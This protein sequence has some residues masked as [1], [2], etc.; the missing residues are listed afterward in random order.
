MKTRMLIM[1]QIME[2]KS[3]NEDDI[4]AIYKEQISEM[5]DNLE[6]KEYLL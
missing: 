2:N 4:A 6:R 5:K 1:Q 3:E